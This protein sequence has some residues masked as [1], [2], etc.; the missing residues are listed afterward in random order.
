MRR[1]C[2]AGQPSPPSSRRGTVVGMADW[3]N[4]WVSD[5]ARRFEYRAVLRVPDRVG[6]LTVEAIYRGTVMT[7]STVEVRRS[8]NPVSERA[9]AIEYPR[10]EAA[11]QRR[12]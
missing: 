1:P 8:A 5:D 3:Y 10:P 4:L 9:F 12:P 7:S 6:K 11:Y 2:R